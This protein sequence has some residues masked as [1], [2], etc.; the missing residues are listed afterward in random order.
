MGE[1]VS[2]EKVKALNAHLKA[3]TN[4][5][6]LF[7]FLIQQQLGKMVF[8]TSLGQEDQVLTHHIG[9]NK[10]PITVFTLDTRRY[11]FEGLVSL[12]V[13]RVKS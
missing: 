10:F 11:I 7:S 6:E 12:V 5:E 9:I 1:K 3:T 13:K 8:S 2:L 4:M